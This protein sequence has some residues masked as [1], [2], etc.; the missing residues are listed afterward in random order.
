M[1]VAQHVNQHY[2]IRTSLGREVMAAYTIPQSDDAIVLSKY[3][4]RGTDVIEL[5]KLEPGVFT[6]LTDQRVIVN[7]R[8]VGSDCVLGPMLVTR[9]N[10]R[11]VIIGSSILKGNVIDIHNVSVLSCDGSFE[12]MGYGYTDHNIQCMC[13]FAQHMYATCEHDSNLLKIIDLGSDE[14]QVYGTIIPDVQGQI[15][16]IDTMNNGQ[17][18]IGVCITNQGRVFM[19][20][21][22]PDKTV[23]TREYHTILHSNELRVEAS[24]FTLIGTHLTTGSRVAEI[25]ELSGIETKSTLVE[26][27]VSD[28]LARK[29]RYI[30]P[31][32][33]GPI[34]HV[35]Q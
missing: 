9:D 5:G 31:R 23:T 34:E 15:V 4:Q 11:E 8:L 30:K 27:I 24:K 18:L 22:M 32:I 16:H 29:I 26:G 6:E 20:D 14:P 2:T 19:I 33:K 7:C 3:L 35:A 13:Y 25:V 1:Y 12:I 21:I 17:W 10:E 28:G